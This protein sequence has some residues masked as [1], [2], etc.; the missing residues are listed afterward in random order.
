MKDIIFSP[1]G[2]VHSDYTINLGTPIQ[3]DE[4]VK[5]TGVIEIFNQFSAGLEDID[6]FSHIYVLYHFHKNIDFKL[7]VKPFMDDNYHGV[8]ATRAP[9]RPNGIGLSL[10]KISSVIENRICVFGID[11]LDKTPVLDIKP[12]IGEFSKMENISMGW[13]SDKFHGFSKT[14]DDGRFNI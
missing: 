1:I 11:I 5:N 9:K 3:P 6:G 10:L 2:I 12:Y 8:F 14:K 13:L 7:S 4:S